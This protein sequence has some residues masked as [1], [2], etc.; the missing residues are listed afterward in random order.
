MKPATLSSPIIG[1]NKACKLLLSGAAIPPAP[2][3]VTLLH[4]KAKCTLMLLSIFMVMIQGTA[5][6]QTTTTPRYA[7]LGENVTGVG[8]FAWVSP[9]NIYTDNTTYASCP[10]ATDYS[11][12]NGEITNYLKATT[13]GFTTATVPANATILGI[14]ATFNRCQNGNTGDYLY[15][16]RV[17][18]VKG[19]TIQSTNK[20]TTTPWVNGAAA[21]PGVTTRSDSYG[22]ATDLW[23]DYT[24]KPADINSSDFGVVL[25]AQNPNS[26]GRAAHV[27]YVTISVTYNTTPPT[28][29]SFTNSGVCSGSGASVV[30]TGTNFTG[31]TDVKFSGASATYTINSP[32]QITAT[33]PATATT[34]TVSV[35][36]ASGTGTSASS[37]TVNPTLTPSVSLTA[38]PGNSIPA[39]STATFTATADNTGGGTVIYNFK[40]NGGSVQNT[41]S[42]IYSS[43]SLTNGNTVSCDIIISGG[44]CL[45]ATN[46]QSGAITMIVNPL[47]SASVTGQTN[48]TCFGVPTGT[49]TVEASGGSGSGYTFSVDNGATYVGSENPYIFTGL[50]ANTPYKI[51]VKDSNESQSPAIP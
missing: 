38:S 5:W 35:T 51:R 23:G 18:L 24:W 31:A 1:C 39:G 13:F 8:S 32:T 22:G 28:V 3:F 43:S 41:T 15:D 50:S 48:L 40:V 30:I 11:L 44:T 29:T 16:Y 10:G 2:Q 45:T 34:G 7:G 26:S 27:D 19:G 25:S 12:N 21:L 46:A 9:T 33:L 37:F 42:N 14:T 49:I 4:N 6:G 47:P 36:T 20:A 17:S